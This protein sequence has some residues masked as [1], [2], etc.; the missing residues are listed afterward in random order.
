M[1]YILISTAEELCDTCIHAEF[2]HGSAIYTTIYY[3]IPIFKRNKRRDD[4]RKTTNEISQCDK[5][6]KREKEVV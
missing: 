4:T 2:H 1:T 6:I 3:T 5:M